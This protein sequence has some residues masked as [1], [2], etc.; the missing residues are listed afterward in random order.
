MF[1]CYVFLLRENKIYFTHY[2]PEKYFIFS[3]FQW[4]N[5]K[6]KP[7]DWRNE[8]NLTFWGAILREK[9]E[10]KI[11]KISQIWKGK[12]FSPRFTT[13]S[14]AKNFISYCKI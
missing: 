5:F 10:K 2:R 4:K 8:K 11:K 12:T 9:M 1:S 3:D 7:K 6:E 14:T 13:F